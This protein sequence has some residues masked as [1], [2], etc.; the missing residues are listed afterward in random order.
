MKNKL[1]I[2]SVSFKL[3]LGGAEKM[4]IENCRLLNP[5]LFDSH[6]I[7][8]HKE[9]I[10]KKDVLKYNLNYHFIKEEFKI[11]SLVKLFQ[12]FDIIHGHTINENPLIYI[13]ANIANV[14]IIVES[15]PMTYM[16]SNNY[17]LV[18]HSICV[19][20]KVNELQAIPKNCSTIY[21]GVDLSYFSASKKK[22][23]SKI[24]LAEVGRA[25]KVMD[26]RLEDIFPELTKKHKDIEAWITGREGKSTEK[27]K[28][29][30]Y[31][32]NLPL[33][34]SKVDILVNLSSSEALSTI[35][36]EAM[37]MGVIPFVS[38]VGGMEEIIDHQK[39][40]FIIDTKDYS[41]VIDSLN[42]LIN[43]FKNNPLQIEKIRD[44]AIRKIKSKFNKEKNIKKLEA[45]Y[46]NLSKSLKGKNCLKEIF[47]NAKMEIIY[48]LEHFCN[49]NYLE[50]IKILEK[51]LNFKDI[52]SKFLIY[53]FL[54]ENHFKLKNYEDAADYFKKTLSIFPENY[55]SNFL[56]A[57]SYYQSKNFSSAI[58]ILKKLINKY[59][60]NILSYLSL[61]NIYIEEK[62]YILAKECFQKLLLNH[63]QYKP[64]FKYLSQIN[65]LI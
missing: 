44:R 53:H 45:L 29:L 46:I 39:D 65:S 9:G 55:K 11:P 25:D 34:L 47:R 12:E 43:L 57:E 20:N 38:K 19:S 27:I 41:S 33:F 40:G 62:N 64:G 13:A 37:A 42:Y 10:L 52:Y 1:K 24:I 23:N 16:S 22:K 48:G 8:T 51:S 61:G 14:P 21:D 50:S 36:M 63:P 6:L 15:I 35:V 4:A 31:Q 49:Q 28:Y 58:K 54:G 17:D 7:I 59:P 26:Y 5:E 18:D 3:T 2:A 32:E 56:L 30:G 60:E